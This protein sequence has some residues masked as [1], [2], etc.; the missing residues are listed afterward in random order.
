MWH[1][2]ACV[3][4]SI[5]L[6]KHI[7]YFYFFSPKRLTSKYFHNIWV[8]NFLLSKCG[9]SIYGYNISLSMTDIFY[10]SSINLNQYIPL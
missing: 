10:K 2:R 4:M 6:F 9:N 7:K 1:I 3:C 8:N 5:T